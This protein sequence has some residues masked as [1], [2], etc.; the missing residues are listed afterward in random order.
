LF[1]KI[2]CLGFRGSQAFIDESVDAFVDRL[3]GK[4]AVLGKGQ[5]S[6]EPLFLRDGIAVC[7]EFFDEA[8]ELKKS[9]KYC[10]NERLV[11]QYEQGKMD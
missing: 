9:R 11:T 8:E 5:C 3:S 7:D 4:V 1:G 6:L 2:F 10:E